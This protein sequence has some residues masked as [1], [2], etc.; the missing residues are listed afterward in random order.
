MEFDSDVPV[1]IKNTKTVSCYS[2]EFKGNII[3]ETFQCITCVESFDQE[4]GL[5][6]HLNMEHGSVI[7]KIYLKLKLKKKLN[8][9]INFHFK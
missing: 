9:E 3:E 8:Y 2:K 4:D 1:M 5:L 7:F 6:N